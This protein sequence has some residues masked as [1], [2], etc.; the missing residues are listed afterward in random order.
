MPRKSRGPYLAVE[1]RG[2][3]R[4][5]H[6]VI[7]DG[8]LK[9]RTGCTEG[10]IGEAEKRLAE[11]ITEKHKT[12]SSN[13]AADIPVA[14]ILLTYARECVPHHAR[15]EVAKSEI[16]RL[17]QYWGGK[18]VSDIK[19]SSCQAYVAW[20]KAVGTPKNPNATAARNE[21]TTLRAALNDW[22]EEKPIIDLPKVF[23]PPMPQSRQEW[24]RRAEVAQ[25]LRAVRRRPDARHVARVIL[26]GVYTG[27]RS[28]AIL[29]LRWVENIEGGWVDVDNGVLYR[30][31]P[32]KRETKK[33]QPPI[34]I[35]RKL[36]MHLKIW[37][38]R[39]LAA[40]IT[41]VV[42]Y[43]GKGIK[44]LR[45]S[46]EGVRKEAALGQHLVLHGFRH[47]AATWLM[48]ARVDPWEACGYLGMT[49]ET[50]QDYA[51]HH[52]DYQ[53]NAASAV[54]PKSR[55]MGTRMGTITV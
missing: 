20:R 6:W 51:H 16:K 22:H 42:H 15:P 11:Y 53:S 54:A 12:V 52:P 37:R 1:D 3:G 5:K 21:L 44:K 14:D 8:S 18:H 39:D 24:A 38:R 32:G 4:G 41:H 26:I 49:L 28:G 17:A 48:Q 30:K 10:R 43:R 31:A 29:G 35:H 9:I 40:G 55:P 50:I 33:R 34:R 19:K 46:W 36:F 45:R 27:T 13:C 7:R 23:V 47:T 2:P 25:L